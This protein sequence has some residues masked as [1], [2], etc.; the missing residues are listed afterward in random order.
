MHLHSINHRN[1]LSFKI[2][3][4]S[5]EFCSRIPGIIKSLVE[6]EGSSGQKLVETHID[7]SKR[8]PEDK[9]PEIVWTKLVL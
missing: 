7:L 3:Q 1:N 6:E 2:I 8:I 5:F 4:A 9:N